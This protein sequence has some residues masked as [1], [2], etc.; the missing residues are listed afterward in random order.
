MQQQPHSAHAFA[1]INIPYTNTGVLCTAV[2][3]C[4][5]VCNLHLMMKEHLPLGYQAVQT[6]AVGLCSGWQ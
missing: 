5:S 1:R 2:L 4:C 6:A 3:V